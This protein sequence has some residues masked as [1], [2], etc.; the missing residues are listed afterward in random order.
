MDNV[1]KGHCR[2]RKFLEEKHEDRMSREN[3][4]MLTSLLALLF[5]VKRSMSLKS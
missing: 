2:C 3:K 5:D 1:E 4:E